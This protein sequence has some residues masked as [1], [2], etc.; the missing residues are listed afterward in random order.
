MGKKIARLK[1]KLVGIQAIFN[2]QKYADIQWREL[3]VNGIRPP[4]FRVVVDW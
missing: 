3:S 1:I 2:K 4:F